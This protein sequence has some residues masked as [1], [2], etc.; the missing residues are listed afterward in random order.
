MRK[1][2]VFLGI[3]SV[4]S[5]LAYGWLRQDDLEYAQKNF[6]M[7][8]LVGE[9]DGY[10]LTP[11][12]FVAQPFIRHIQWSPDGNY[13][14]LVQTAMRFEGDAQTL[15]AEMRHRLLAWSRQTKRISILWESQKTNV[16]IDPREDVRL[17]FFKD[18]SACVFAVR[19]DKD[20]EKWG[21]YHATIGGRIVKLGEFER[22]ALLAP[23][24]GNAC[25]LI[26]SRYNSEAQQV[27]YTYTLIEATGR[28]GGIRPL[29]PAVV[30][31]ALYLFAG[32]GVNFSFWYAD[33]KQLIVPVIEPPVADEEVD[34]S[35]EQRYFLWNP[36]TNQ[37]REIQEAQLR[38]YAKKSPDA[39]VVYAEKSAQR[40]QHKGAQATTQTTWLSEGSEATLVAAD[41]T[42]ASVAPNGDAILYVA[43]GAAFYR[44]L[45]RLTGD[46]LRR[47]REAAKIARYCSQGKQIGLA[48]L[49]YTQ[50][51]DEL[52]PP[53]FGNEMV[54]EII[55]IYLRDK[56]V[57][58]IDGTFAFRYLLDGQSLADIE[59]PVNTEIGYL[60]T[61]EG[62]VVIYVDGHV[63][64]KPNR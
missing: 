13:A 43:H 35:S 26:W 51:Y 61:P 57:F 25:Y 30:E 24:E 42:L 14:I 50:D 45:I 23:P 15:Q 38:S 29:P 3:A 44:S 9:K 52:F 16:D 32:S 5:L 28:T 20:D 33:G 58:S 41:S 6:H 17:A 27:I 31:I 11:P 49:M 12:E 19:E 55:S 40:L 53:N 56:E 1:L 59:L 4:A 21:V 47:M 60:E 2:F 54:A 39:P 7:T 48:F 36:R 63:K 37:M 34:E 8:M 64:W 18:G 62:R 46:D 10:I 22:P